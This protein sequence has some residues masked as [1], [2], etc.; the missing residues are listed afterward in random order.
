MFTSNFVMQKVFAG[1]I[2][3]LRNVQNKHE[4]NKYNI[5]VHIRNYLDSLNDVHQI[6]SCCFWRKNHHNILILHFV[7]F[8]LSLFFFYSTN[9]WFLLL[10]TNILSNFIRT[11]SDSYLSIFIWIS[12]FRIKDVI[13][14][15]TIINDLHKQ[16][17]IY[18]CIYMYMYQQ[19]LNIVIKIIM[20]L[21]D[22]QSDQLAFFNLVYFR[23]I[24]IFHWNWDKIQRIPIGFTSFNY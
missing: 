10:V 3:F 23:K 17:Y 20:V 9:N 11:K 5:N 12:K 24:I 1:S 4:S 2:F 21:V 16:A 15:C 13:F 8:P 6:K 7:S 18:I 14:T 19:K 22:T